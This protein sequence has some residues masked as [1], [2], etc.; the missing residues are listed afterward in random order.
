MEHRG[1]FVTPAWFAHRIPF[2][3]ITSQPREGQVLLAAA[4]RDFARDRHKRRVHLE[5]GVGQTYG[6]RHPAYPGGAKRGAVDL[7][8]CPSRRVAD[9]EGPKGVVVGAPKLDGW[10][11]WTRPA[12]EQPTVALTWHWDA[13]GIS[14]EAGT[15]WWEYRPVLHD[16]VKTGWA[17]IGHAHPRIQQNVFPHYERAGIE[18]VTDLD[19]VFSRADVLVA[20]NTSALPE[21]AVATGRPLVFV[22]SKE[23]RRGVNHG[24]RFW[25]WT[26]GQVQC[27]HPDGLQAAIEFAWDDP[28]PIRAARHEMIEDAYGLLDGRA[29]ERCVEAILDLR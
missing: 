6:D 4:V 9:L 29:A 2:P 17:I 19:E 22:N 12:N 15:A 1:M 16:L 20:D 11:G 27:D 18:V 28:A 5:H 25:R 3:T 26:E 7:F 8:L 23:Y 14:P 10:Y 21:F 24:C 13:S